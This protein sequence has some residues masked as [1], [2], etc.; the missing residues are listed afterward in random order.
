MVATKSG[1]FVAPLGPKGLLIVK[2]TSDPS[3]IM[4]VTDGTEG[5]LYFYRMVA[6]DDGNG[7]E[8]LVFANRREGVGL[9]VFDPGENRRNVHTMKFEG[10]DVIDDCGLGANSLSAIAISKNAEVVWIKD[11]SKRYDPI[12]LKLGGV[13]GRVYRVL[14]T[15][16]HLFVLSSKALYVWSN[17]VDRIL[18]ENAS[19]PSSLPLVIP[20]EA[21]DMTLFD[22]TYLMLVMATNGLMSPK[23]TDLEG[24]PIE[25]DGAA[26]QSGFSNELARR[27]KLEDL[28]PEW[29]N[30]D[31]AQ[32]IL[33]GAG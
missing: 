29:K 16:R 18:F 7:K 19:S 33:I 10:I 2:P 31:I 12:A 15:T 32:G 9:S 3:Q 21:V 24:Q 1:Y 11:T 20:M 28:H 14:A 26:H 23:I 25:D 5:Q 4:Q 22:D 30:S 17:L 13:E 27:T 6:L 8:T